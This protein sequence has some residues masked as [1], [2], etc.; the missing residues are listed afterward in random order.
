MLSTK[1]RQQLQRHLSQGA[2]LLKKRQQMWQSGAP[3]TS[4]LRI[5][6]RLFG[7]ISI[8]ADHAQIFLLDAWPQHPDQE[9]IAFLACFQCSNIEVFVASLA[10]FT[11]KLA[12]DDTYQEFAPLLWLGSPADFSIARADAMLAISDPLL[13]ALMADFLAVSHWPDTT[14]RYLAL[15]GDLALPAWINAN[16]QLTH[17]SPAKIARSLMLGSAQA[18]SL[19]LNYLEENSS[20][21]LEWQWLVL[22]SSNSALELFFQH[23]EQ[24]PEHLWAAVVNRSSQLFENLK[25]CFSK[26]HLQQEAAWVFQQL[27]SQ[28]LPGE[29][30]I[31]EINSRNQ[32]V[33]SDLLQPIWPEGIPDNKLSAKTDKQFILWLLSLPVERQSLGWL[34]LAQRW[35]TV[36]PDMSR[37][38]AHRQVALVNTK[39]TE[40]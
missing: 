8:L 36:L 18:Q 34:A 25:R 17:N 27:T 10:R 1:D 38:W 11:E 16:E 23:C 5:E 7:S 33:N 40:E 31:A 28:S 20:N 6:Q 3:I 30:A 32:P 22:L 15:H 2:Q 39:L 12:A 19:L 37:Q 29:P 4:A 24:H 35:Q 13:N 21:R 9:K 26:A 14:T